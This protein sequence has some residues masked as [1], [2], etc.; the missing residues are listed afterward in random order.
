MNIINNGAYFE[1]TDHKTFLDFCKKIDGCTYSVKVS[2]F[3]LVI[4]WLQAARWVNGQKELRFI[5]AYGGCLSIPSDFVVPEKNKIGFET[6]DIM[7]NVK[8]PTVKAALEDLE[9]SKMIFRFGKDDYFVD[10]SAL[11]TLGSAFHVPPQI[12]E[13]RALTSAIAVAEMLGKTERL[14]NI[15][16][17]TEDDLSKIVAFVG[18]RYKRNNLTD[19]AIAAHNS[20][21]Q[22]LK[23]TWSDTESHVYLTDNTKSLENGQIPIID[24]LTSDTCH[25]ADTI[26][27]G[28]GSAAC[29]EEY[30][31]SSTMAFPEKNLK[32]FLKAIDVDAEAQKYR[33]ILKAVNACD[34]KTVVKAIGKDISVSDKRAIV[35]KVRNG[36]TP[37][38]AIFCHIED[39]NEGFA[40]S[41][42]RK[43]FINLGQYA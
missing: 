41:E 20:G 43:A 34:V 22:F 33:N 16:V 26:N 2:M 39:V 14:Y 19:I 32:G 12:F 7:F 30:F 4:L 27:F 42:Y 24:I 18:R 3:D 17:R 5:Q 35:N 36:L 6:E 11:K 9:D 28:W 31:I 8:N 38:D 21:F 29:P 25:F 37:V 10:N 15:L 1:T 23:G 13:D 40:K